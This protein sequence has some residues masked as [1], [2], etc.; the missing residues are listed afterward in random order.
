MA[1]SG[2]GEMRSAAFQKQARAHFADFREAVGRLTLLGQSL[3]EK[4]LSQLPVFSFSE[5]RFEPWAASVAGPVFSLW[6]A[7]LALLG[8]TGARLGWSRRRASSSGPTK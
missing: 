2:T 8:A 4:N 7:A 6:F 1:L 5:P 3:N